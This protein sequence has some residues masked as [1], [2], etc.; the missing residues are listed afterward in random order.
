M[1]MHDSDLCYLS[2]SS[3]DWVGKCLLLQSKNQELLEKQHHLEEKN[4]ELD[5][6]SHTVA[7]DL[8]NS[9]SAIYN[10]AEFLR[11]NLEQGITTEAQTDLHLILRHSQKMSD[12]IESL[13]LLAGTSRHREIYME[14]VDMRIILDNAWVRVTEFL[15]GDTVIRMPHHWPWALGYPAWLEEV[16]I[17]YISN[18]VKYGGTPANVEL[19]AKQRG[20]WV[21]FWVRD[22]GPG[23]SA[24]EQQRLFTPFTRLHPQRADGHGLGLSIVERIMRKLGGKAGVRSAPG[25]GCQFYFLLPVKK[26]EADY[27]SPDQAVMTA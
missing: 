9:L 3:A 11:E 21:E 26:D 20:D 19:G 27:F 8:K 22:N 13:L 18:A 5:A 10:H 17:N 6:F 7:H 23:L 14:P 4:A 12:I 16:W 25:E 1:D 24:Q 2:G 15:S